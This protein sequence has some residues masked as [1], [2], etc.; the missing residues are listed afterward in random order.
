MRLSKMK[1]TFDSYVS[2]RSEYY[3]KKVVAIE[4]VESTDLSNIYYKRRKVILEITTDTET[5]YHD[6][7]HKKG[8][9]NDQRFTDALA[10]FEKFVDGDKAVN[11]TFSI[12]DIEICEATNVEEYF[13]MLEDSGWK[14]DE[15]I[16]KPAW[17]IRAE[18]AGW[19][20]PVK[21]D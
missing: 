10:S 1:T 3:P 12:D 20:A 14:R 4:Y 21:E 17:Q 6:N 16:L 5:S 9:F 11:Y 2:V 8:S 18:R 13:K 19:I 15:D 7:P